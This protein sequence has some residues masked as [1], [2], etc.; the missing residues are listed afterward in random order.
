MDKISK[1]IYVSVFKRLIDIVFSLLAIVLLAPLFLT[2][3]LLLLFVNHGSPFYLQMRP[4][5]NAKIFRL[6]KFKTMEDKFDASGKLL[7][8]E[9]RLTRIG[10]LMRITSI[11]E[12]PQLLNVLIGNMSIVGPRPL[13][14]RYLSLYNHHQERRHEVL[15]GITGWTQ[16]NGRNNLGWKEKFD[17][18]IYY[19]D[20]ISFWLDMKIIFLTFI[21]VIKREGVNQVGHATSSPFLGNEIDYGDEGP[22]IK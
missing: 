15:P 12:L 1:R 9:F 17:L 11:D 4:G 21:K 5:K 18:D 2:V 6:V 10:K 22:E 3:I 13:L 19:V 7:P 16:V 8:D 20:N 14:V